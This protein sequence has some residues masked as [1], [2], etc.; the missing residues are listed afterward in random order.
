MK[1]VKVYGISNLPK[2]DDLNDE[3]L[4]IVYVKE[5]PIIKKIIE[6][7]IISYNNLN[8]YILIP[9]IYI[10]DEKKIILFF[11]YLEFSYQKYCL[12]KIGKT[13]KKEELFLFYDYNINYEVVNKIYNNVKEIKKYINETEV[14]VNYISNTIFIYENI[15]DLVIPI[16][17][18]IN[19][20][21]CINLD[22]DNV[23]ILSIGTKGTLNNKIINYIK[24]SIENV[25]FK[26]GF[27]IKN[28]NK[29]IRLISNFYK[30]DENKSYIT[31]FL[32]LTKLKKKEDVDDDDDINIINIDDEIFN[33]INYN[34]YNS[35]EQKCLSIY[36]KCNTIPEY[37]DKILLND[38]IITIEILFEKLCNVESIS[39]DINLNIF[40]NY[41]EYKK[42]I[43]KYINFNEKIGNMNKD[44]YFNYDNIC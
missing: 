24:F 14:N 18:I 15:L 43:Y 26:I 3:Y 36:N 13:K 25:I 42:Q 10:N 40:D 12:F 30:K 1:I 27:N 20:I 11:E 39:E 23:N 28:N 22:I 9:K 31:S 32:E 37:F 7:I 41:I 29:K 19:K 35:I 34:D 6:Y 16:S 33:N 17:N 5:I 21:L 44:C 8:W 38:N 2:L 4:F